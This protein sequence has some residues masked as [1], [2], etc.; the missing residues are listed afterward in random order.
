MLGQLVVAQLR[1]R[2][3]FAFATVGTGASTTVR[4]RRARA[5]LYL[6]LAERHR[7]RREDPR[8]VAALVRA[9]WRAHAEADDAIDAGS[10]MS[11]RQRQSA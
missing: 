5:S 8:L 9:A 11:D 7:E 1:P 2:A 3:S 10:G 6:R 4:T